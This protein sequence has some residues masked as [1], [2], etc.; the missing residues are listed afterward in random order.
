MKNKII[1]LGLFLSVVLFIYGCST[2]GMFTSI[3][4]TNVELRQ[5]NYKIVAT[6]VSG[7]SEAGYLIG[8]TI[9][10][11]S[12]TNTLAFV[13]VSGTGMLYKE[14]LENLWDNYKEKYGNIEGEKL[15]LVNVRYDTDAL[16][17][18]LYT[19]ARIYVRADVIRFE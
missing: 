15:A 10:S 3:N 19:S 13:R 1:L 9:P 2:S 5:A 7:E 18:F 12:L 16:N 6:N 11:G 4:S 17:L 8:I 14:A